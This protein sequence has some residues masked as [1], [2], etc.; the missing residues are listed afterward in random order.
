[1]K[2]SAK[3]DAYLKFTSFESQTVLMTAG[4]V[5]FRFIVICRVPPNNKNKILKSSLI[6]ELGYLLE[7]TPTFSGKLVL[8]GNINLQMDS[9]CDPEASDLR[10]LLD[11]F[12]LI[13]HVEDVTHVCGHTLDLVITSATG[14]SLHSCD[15]SH[16]VSDNNAINITLRPG[17]L[18]PVRKCITFRKVKQI[19]SVEYSNDI[20]ASIL[21]HALPSDVEDMISC[22]NRILTE[23][24]DKHAPLRTK[25][26]AHLSLQPWMNR[27]ILEARRK[28]RNA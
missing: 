26:I 12:G 16:F 22:Y 18:L 27:T 19:D 15:V 13:Q 14:N 21:I 17:P 24:L 25:A 23:L 8:L 20:K 4:S 7:Q 28:R 3:L 5:T 2:L 6:N 11:S 1:M 10:T 9:R